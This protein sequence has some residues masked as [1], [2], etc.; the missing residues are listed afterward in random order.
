MKNIFINSVQFICD[1][2]RAGNIL[3]KA[4]ARQT[5]LSCCKE[6]YSTI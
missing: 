6:T 2:H 3:R 1:K 4:Q 5:A